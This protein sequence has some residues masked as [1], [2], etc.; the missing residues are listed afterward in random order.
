MEIFLNENTSKFSNNVEGVVNTTL[1]TKKRLLP[2]NDISNTFSLLEQYN[3]ERDECRKFRLIFNISPICSNVLFNVK[4][5]I[6][7]NEGSSG[8]TALFHNSSSWDKEKYASSASNISDITHLHA[9][10]DTEYSHK[11]LGGFVYHCGLDIFNNHMLRNNGFVH[12]NK[13]KEENE[14]YNTIMDT[15]RYSD[16]D[17]VKQNIKIEG[18]KE[19]LTEMHLYRYDSMLSMK[20]AFSERCEE[21]DGWWGFINP[22]NINIENRND[23]IRINQML[24][25]NKPCEFIDLYPDRTLFSFNPKFN[26][27]RKRIEKNWDYCI[28]YPFSNDHEIINEICGGINGGIRINCKKLN[29]TSGVYIVQCESYFK[30]NLKVG[31]LISIYYKNDNG[32]NLFRGKIRVTSV[33]DL[34]GNNKDKIFSIK[35]SD[36]ESIWINVLENKDKDEDISYCWFKKCVNGTECSYYARKF[37]KIRNIDGEELKS[38]INK[39]AFG[40]NI[41]GDD[42]SQLL[43]LDDINID[44]LLDNNKRP[45]SEVYLTIIKRNAGY[46]DWASNGKC[47]SEK[48]EVSHCFGEVTSGFDFS[49]IG[50]E[51]EPINYNIHK[52]HNI[53]AGTDNSQI[54]NDQIANTFSVWGEAL[55]NKPKPLESGIT[56]EKD[57]FYGDIVEYDF[58]NAKETII[59]PIYHRFNTVQREWVPDGGESLSRYGDIIEDVI[60]KD[61]YDAALTDGNFEVK[62][63]FINNIG[64]GDVFYTG[65]SSKAGQDSSKL[66]LGNIMPEGYFYKAHTPVTLI[67]ESSDVIRAEAKLINT[68]NFV[69]STSTITFNAP[70]NFGFYKGDFI[71]F[72]NINNSETYWTEITKVENKTTLTV[73]IF[74]NEINEGNINYLRAYWSPYNVPVYA[75]LNAKKREFAWRKLIMQSELKPQ[76]ELYETTFSNGRLYLEKN[77]NF[78]LR[79]QDPIG[80]YGLSNPIYKENEEKINTMAKYIIKG[81]EPYDFSINEVRI[82]NFDNC[83]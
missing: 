35:F 26:K 50:P 47:N 79:R 57:D 55:K 78:F 17:V 66:I 62:S 71:A 29:N 58:A 68:T 9:L 61:D 64:T 83:Y 5:E 73:S 32:I 67:E 20:R 45:V 63:R 22:G 38:D 16:G 69:Q 7:K 24:S 12:V 48:T 30:H 49:G 19:G 42:V 10:R 60:N 21:R 59:S 54:A 82:N 18:N 2:N 53:S 31:D 15:L 37:K 70:T 51:N 27:A 56:I 46:K 72:Y 41:Y 43:F 6:I 13:V 3:K 52:L 11:E 8:A 1:S 33:G 44:G 65:P 76:S 28:T 81:Y 75:K 77:I 25:N 74:D 14:I 34:T 80:E 23:N 36:I 4:T 39:I 40:R